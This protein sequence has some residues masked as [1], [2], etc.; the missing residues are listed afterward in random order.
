M[1]KALA[2]SALGV[3]A[4]LVLGVTWTVASAAT[5]LPGPART[6]AASIDGTARLIEAPELPAPL[7]GARS[8][9]VRQMRLGGRLVER[10]Y[11]APER[12]AARLLDRSEEEERWTM[13]RAPAAPPLP[14]PPAPPVLPAPPEAHELEA[15]IEARIEARRQEIESRIESRM[16]RVRERVERRVERRVDGHEMGRRLLESL[17]GLRLETNLELG[18]LVSEALSLAAAE[19]D[20][21]EI[22]VDGTRVRVVLPGLERR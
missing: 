18:A 3:A 1:R 8:A 10:I 19:L 6:V 7:D 13:V 17:E 4:W 22:D 9:V 21:T 14:E 2:Y 12:I 5:G 16:E 15:A 20:G 11:R